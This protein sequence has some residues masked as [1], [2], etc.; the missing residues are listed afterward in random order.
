[1]VMSTVTEVHSG[2]SDVIMTVWYLLR[3]YYLDDTL[4]YLFLYEIEI[5]FC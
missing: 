5:S 2:A 1:M 4:G 3:Y